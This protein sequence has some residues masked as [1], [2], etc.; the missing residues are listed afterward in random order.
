MS[1]TV[2]AM[3]AMVPVLGLAHIRLRTAG[4]GVQDFRPRGTHARALAGRE[5]D[6]KTGPLGH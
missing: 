6:R 4:D 3:V 2:A 5:H 1:F